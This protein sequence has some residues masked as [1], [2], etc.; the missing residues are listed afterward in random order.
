MISEWLAYWQYRVG[1]TL[2]AA[3][4]A[5]P[6]TSWSAQ[7]QSS[8]RLWMILEGT[9]VLSLM[10]FA[11]TILFVDLRLLGLVL[12][13]VPVSRVSDSVLPWTLG[14]FAVTLL[15]GGTLFLSNPLDY[16]HNFAFRVKLAFLLLAALNIFW[17]HVRVQAN[18]AS[19]DTLERPPRP[20]RIAAA[21]SL[22]L[23]FCIIVAGRY[24]AY[25]WTKCMNPS[26]LV[27]QVAQCETYDAVLADAEK[28]LAS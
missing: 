26:W 28:G 19:W 3:G 17:F 7:L 8:E 1:A 20:A 13:Q 18:R 14:G 21:T 22:G 27:A 23:W 6:D 24:M 4:R 12:R 25:D 9:H 5:L 10:V 16:F 11:G 15:T 2:D